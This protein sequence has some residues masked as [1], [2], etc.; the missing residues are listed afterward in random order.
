MRAGSLSFNPQVVI[1]AK[2]TEDDGTASNKVTRTQSQAVA[3]ASARQTAR[4]LSA[5]R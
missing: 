2:L 1:E 4:I 3:T 5:L